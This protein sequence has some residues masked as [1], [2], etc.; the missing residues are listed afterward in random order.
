MEIYL[1]RITFCHIHQVWNVWHVSVPVFSTWPVPIFVQGCQQQCVD[2]SS[3]VP[4]HLSWWA[5]LQRKQHSLCCSCIYWTSHNPGWS[6]K[7]TPAHA[8]ELIQTPKMNK[9]KELD[10][11]SIHNYELH[12]WP[13]IRWWCIISF[14]CFLSALCFLLFSFPTIESVSDSWNVCFLVKL[15]FANI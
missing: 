14:V 8:P 15:A 12:I 3:W 13:C 7:P 5:F 1:V 4:P 6:G 2:N 9:K 11:T 10:N